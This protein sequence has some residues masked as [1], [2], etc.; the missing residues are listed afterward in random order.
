MK[1]FSTIT[2]AAVC[3]AVLSGC[4]RST[5]SNLDRIVERGEIVVGVK[6]D[7]PPFGFRDKD[8]EL[9]GFDVDLTNAIAGRLG[10]KPRFVPLTTAERIPA[11]LSGKVD[12]LAACMTITRE[13]AREVDF[14]MQYFDTHQAL[15]VS[16]GSPIK[17]YVD[18]AGKRAG[19]V[20]GS[21]AMSLVKVVQPDVAVV[22]FDKYDDAL[23]ALTG[24]EVEA[25]ATDYIIL[26]GLLQGRGDKLKIV[27]QFGWEP[28]GIAMRQND[29]KLR[30][31]INEALQDMWD[32]GAF[33][34]IHDNWFGEHG[35][36]PTKVPFSMTTFPRGGLEK[37]G[38]Q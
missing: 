24:G 31:R 22:A 3:A 23:K 9:W 26:A 17:D 18:L 29:S 2:F 19:V 13:R 10:V 7:T 5:G 1:L 27:G 6:A 16:L 30:G 37:A 21:T 25:I 36:F 11:L 38:R 20:K 12:I 33:Q 14:S 28:Y 15:L 34:R 4:A 8:G 35:R 32:E